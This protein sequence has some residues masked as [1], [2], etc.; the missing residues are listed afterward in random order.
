MFELNFLH[1]TLLLLVPLLAVTTL[2]VWHLNFRRRL[3]AR[4]LYGEPRLVDTYSQ[5]LRWRKQLFALIL[6]S[7][8]LTML[9]VAAAGP[10]LPAAPVQVPRGSAQVVAVWDVSRSML[11]E[12]EYRSFLSASDSALP[13]GE[14]PFGNRIDMV[15]YIVVNQLMPALTGN[16]LGIVTYSGN[17]WVQAE[18][19]SDFAS[20]RWVLDNWVVAGSAPGG[21]SDYAEGLKSAI[22][23]FQE[24][25]ASD[26]HERVVVLFSDGGFTGTAS[27][28]SEAVAMLRDNGVR[29]IVVG[30]GGKTAVPLP[31]YNSHG[32]RTGYMKDDD[33]QIATAALEE[34]NL[35]DL[36]SQTGGQYLQ[37]DPSSNLDIKWAPA[38]AGSKLEQQLA[39][40]YHYPLV[41]ALLLL[42]IVFLRNLRKEAT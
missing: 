32:F 28:L 22:A 8:A 37:L 10:R 27:G 34:Q 41:A 23:V 20:M 15:R 30:V 14:G 2:S 42:S 31:Q 38:L 11:A 40:I 12:A 6:W 13:E 16:E 24:A 33:G 39:D 17:G 36:A 21:G 9:A 1:P 18:L 19:M 5:P 29:L 35:I 4:K 25:G 7:G 3:R 26:G